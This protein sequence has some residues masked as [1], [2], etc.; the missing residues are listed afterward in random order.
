M[1]RLTAFFCVALFLASDALARELPLPSYE[2]WTA[3]CG[4]L[5]SNRSLKGAPPRQLLPL[6]KFAEFDAVLSAFLE[7]SKTGTLAEKTNWVGTVPDAAFFDNAKAYFLKS[8]KF[9]PFAQTLKLGI[10]TQIYFRADLH[11]DIHSLIANLKWLNERSYLQGFA[12]AR[13]NFNM[14]FLGDYTDRG[15]YG[16]EVLY[17]LL[18]LKLANPDRVFLL[19]GNHEEVSLQGRYGFFQEGARKYGAEFNAQKVGRASDYLP[20]VL[21]LG[22]AGNFL[23]CNHGG[24]EPGYNPRELL[25][26]DGNTRFQLLGILKQREFLTKNPEWLATADPASRQLAAKVLQ[27]FTPDDPNTPMVLGFVWNDFTVVA[28]EPEFELDP[29]RALVY[30]RKATQFILQKSGSAKN[31]VH[32]LFRGHQHSSVLNPMMRRL[33]ASGG[34]FRHWQDSDSQS[35]LNSAPSDLQKQLERSE[36]RSIPSGSVWTFNVGPDSGYG[37]GC[38]YGFDAF[39]IVT[40]AEN[41]NDWKLDVINIGISK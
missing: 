4:K 31:K 10:G 8:A 1:N 38:G 26:A 19:R 5:P 25:D 41:F 21:Y 22:T 39:G 6:Q 9:Q 40:T 28:G 34:V 3:V 2:N 24:M 37:A 30:G 27:D 18:R 23:Q 16:V 11:G 12:I 36:Q 13:T 33:V 29:G 15:A 14:V 7:Q 20:V 35:R 17:T 32:A